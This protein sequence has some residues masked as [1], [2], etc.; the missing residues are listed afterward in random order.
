MVHNII[1]DRKIDINIAELHVCRSD[2]WN[3]I[4]EEQRESLDLTTADDGEFW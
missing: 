3:T 1:V 2:E 4:T